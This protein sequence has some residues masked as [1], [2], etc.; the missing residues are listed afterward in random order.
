[1]S[2]KYTV[3][4]SGTIIH[5][6][7]STTAGDCS[8]R[9]GKKRCTFGRPCGAVAAGLS[10]DMVVGESDVMSGLALKSETNWC[11]QHDSTSDLLCYDSLTCLLD[12]PA[13]T[14]HTNS[15]RLCRLQS[16]ID[17]ALACQCSGNRL[18]GNS[19][20]RLELRNGCKLNT[21][22]RH[23]L[24]GRIIGI[25]LLDRIEHEVRERRGFLVIGRS[26]SG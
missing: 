16:I 17:T 8:S 3:I 24:D 12:I 14:H 4:A 26:I 25:S 11:C 10:A 7:S 5:K 22:I 23:R 18:T 6:N 15:L 9:T 2:E 19:P 21:G 1:M 20:N 13:L